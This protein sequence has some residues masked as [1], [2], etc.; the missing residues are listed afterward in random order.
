M[1]PEGYNEITEEWDFGEFNTGFIKLCFFL[2]A[3]LCVG[4]GV[5][6]QR[7]F[8]FTIYIN[9]FFSVCVFFFFFFLLFF[10]GTVLYKSSDFF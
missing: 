4:I 9:R 5:G 6:C 3:G 10:V 1:C 7:V 2:Y 8:I